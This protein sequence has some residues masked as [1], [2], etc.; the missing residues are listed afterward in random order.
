MA[1]N[2]LQAE[3]AYENHLSNHQAAHEGLERVKDWKNSLGHQPFY[4]ATLEDGNDKL[5]QAQ[6]TVE[7]I[8]ALFAAG[9]DG[10][11]EGAANLVDATYAAA[12]DGVSTLINL[13]RL[14]TDGYEH[15]LVDELAGEA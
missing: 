1:I 11:D 9:R 6:G 10:P 5:R 12:L 3:S 2:T 13:A 4:C 15:R 8:S 7:V 14:E